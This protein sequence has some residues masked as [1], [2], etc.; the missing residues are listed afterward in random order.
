MRVCVCTEEGFGADWGLG[1]VGFPRVERGG[2]AVFPGGACWANV[3]GVSGGICQGN[4]SVATGRRP[5]GQGGVQPSSQVGLPQQR[6]F[7]GVGG[8]VISP[9]G[10]LWAWTP[11][12]AYQ[13]I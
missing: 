11:R 9:G 5:Q 1:H 12:E 2:N 4:V 7:P 3:G 6:F 8:G 10:G 13:N